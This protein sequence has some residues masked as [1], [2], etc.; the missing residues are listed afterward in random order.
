MKSKEEI[1]ARIAELREDRAFA[2]EQVE[3]NAGAPGLGYWR[4]R[5]R[6]ISQR[7][8]ELEWVMS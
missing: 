8:W 4:K 5:V 7:I 6:E 3:A 2:D 1:E